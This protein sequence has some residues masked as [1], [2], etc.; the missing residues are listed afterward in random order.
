MD[1]NP[2]TTMSTNVHQHEMVANCNL[3][4]NKGIYVRRVVYNDKYSQQQEIK[5]VN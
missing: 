5:C 1:L 2:S 3:E 4:N